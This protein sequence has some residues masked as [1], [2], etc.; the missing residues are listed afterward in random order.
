MEIG[1]QVSLKNFSSINIGG[2]ARDFVRADTV[3]ELADVVKTAKDLR[4]PLFILGGGTNIL[5]G[6]GQIDGVVVKPAIRFMEFDDTLIRAGA[7]IDMGEIVEK[8]ITRGMAG[9]D[10]FGGLPGTLGGAIYG[11]A[12]CFGGEMKDIV[13]EVESLNMDTLEIV[14]RP[15]HECGFGYRM[16]IFKEKKLPEIILSATLGLKRGDKR[17]L[18]EGMQSRVKYRRERQPLEYPNIGSIFKNVPVDDLTEDLVAPHRDAIKTDPFPVIP[19]GYLMDKAK[20]KGFGVGG[21]VVSH[22]NPAFIVNVN[23]ASSRDVLELIQ[24]VKNRIMDRFGIH[25]EEEIRIVG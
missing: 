5:W 15:N 22:K 23:S 9:L 11:N 25:I 21:A 18:Y 17:I 13:L 10:Y 4:L 20:L 16:S 1:K 8:T 12:G 3:D 24:Y 14:R 19:L 7:G 2:T 6:D